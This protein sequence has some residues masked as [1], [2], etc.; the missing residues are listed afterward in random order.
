MMV[1][2]QISM[3]IV[4][5]EDIPRQ[6]QSIKATAEN[7]AQLVKFFKEMEEICVASK[8]IGL[9]AA[10]LGVAEKLFI[11]KYRS[12]TGWFANC[13]YTGIGEKIESLEGCLSLPHRNFV[14]PRY[15]IV[16]VVGQIV[17]E[18][19]VKPFNERLTDLPAIVFQHEIDHC[20]G[21]LISE[22][23]KE[24]KNE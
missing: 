24:V 22:I 12:F 19:G 8:G 23:G 1:L 13:Y 16:Y 9:A 3:E 14:V 15:P 17:T 5:V 2:E 11:I 7:F 10:Q 20:E 21:I 4:K 18:T 6:C